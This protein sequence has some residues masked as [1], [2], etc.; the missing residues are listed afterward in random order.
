MFS[1]NISWAFLGKSY[2]CSMDGIN[3]YHMDALDLS[4]LKR[5]FREEGKPV[6]YGKHDY[7][8]RQ[9][10]R[11]FAVAYVEEGAFRFVRTD[12]AGNEHVVGYSFRDSF[13]AEYSACLCGR[14]ALADVQAVVKSELY[15]LPYERLRRF[16]ELSP[17]HQRLGRI[18][19]E[20]M[21]VMTYRR[22]L[23]ILCCTP[24]E[25]YVGVMKAYPDLKEQRPLKE[26]ASYVGVTPETVSAIR[27][28]LLKRS[29]S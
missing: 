2:F 9:G 3:D 20:Q 5:F 10:E 19:A 12:D 16:W 11:A 4:V 22:L 25:R 18:V 6:A 21:F 1:G 27:R 29:R 23:D 26:I 8:V 7:F 24:E 14:A 28:N 13:V 17:E 15:V